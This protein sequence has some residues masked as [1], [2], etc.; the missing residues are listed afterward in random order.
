[1]FQNIFHVDGRRRVVRTPFWG[2]QLR[3]EMKEAAMEEIA[4]LLSSLAYHFKR[5]CRTLL[6]Y[7]EGASDI[8]QV[9]GNS[10]CALRTVLCQKDRD[11][12]SLH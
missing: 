2:V 12:D 11:R 10:W 4:S 1:M 9:Y 3:K 5:F 6:L 8:L 7:P